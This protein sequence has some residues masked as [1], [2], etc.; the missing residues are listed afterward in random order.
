M[1]VIVRTR[2]GHKG[3]DLRSRCSSGVF[4]TRAIGASLRLLP[5]ASYR[6]G[7][8]E[9]SNSHDEASNSLGRNRRIITLNSVDGKG[10]GPGW[11][12]SSGILCFFQ[13][14]QG[15]APCGG[16][17]RQGRKGDVGLC[18]LASP[19]WLALF[20]PCFTTFAFPCLGASKA[21][22]ALT[23]TSEEQQ[24]LGRT[25]DGPTS[26]PTSTAPH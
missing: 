19:H 5:V 8:G 24:V 3:I 4:V 12:V 1:G 17:W 13:H 11:L 2:T 16:R 10:P 25:T 7:V 21:A 23:Y 9:A 22:R 6:I 26:N 20:S 15:V 18:R 14:H